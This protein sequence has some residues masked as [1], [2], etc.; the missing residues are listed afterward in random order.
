V[1]VL[2]N[3]RQVGGD[4]LKSLSGSRGLTVENAGL[5]VSG[6]QN[7][8]DFRF[9]LSLTGGG[10]RIEVIAANGYSEGKDIVEVNWQ[11]ARQSDVILPNLWILAI[12]VNKYDE[13]GINNLDYS[14]ADARGIIDAF[15]SQEG[16]VYRKVNSLLIADGSATPP[17][18]ENIKDNLSY[19]SQAGQRDVVL[20]FIAGHGMNDANGNFLFL[21]SDASFDAGGNIRASRA[22]SHREIYSVLDVPGQKL[23]FI[24]SCHSEGVSGKKTRAVDNNQLVR[25]LMDNSTVIFTSSRGSELSQESREFGHGIFTYSIIQGM[26]GEAD[27]IRDGKITMKELD[28]YVSETVPSLTGGA[29]HPTTT[30]P[31]GYVNFNVAQK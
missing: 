22:V 9:P 23:V 7:R 1:R 10:N 20:L 8:V 21:P 24:D 6:D 26:K 16:K 15:K 17:T 14:V 25:G 27:L 19:V 5:L 31:D 12:G 4:D 28:T 18:A 2:V 11:N 30:T 13:P 29:Q 3:G